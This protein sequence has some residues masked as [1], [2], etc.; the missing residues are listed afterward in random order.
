VNA[1][2]D[3]RVADYFNDTFVCTYLKVGTFQIIGGQKVGGNVASYWCLADGSV[4]HAVPG[5]MEANKLLMEARWAYETR[6]AALT[7][8][9]NLVTGDPSMKKYESFVK[10]AHT[11]RYYAELHPGAARSQS[12]R[13]LPMAMPAARTQQAQA[14]WLLAR[15][16]LD[17]IDSVYPIVWT[18]ILREQ[19]SGL[20][21]EQR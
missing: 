4:L 1:L 14:H 19:L 17:K 21:V 11:E 20:P 5:K 7:H 6:K 18:Q 12:E 3:Q 9:T 2:A 10:K 16:P 15:N 8:C 13:A